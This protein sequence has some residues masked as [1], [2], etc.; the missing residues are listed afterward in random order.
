M[1]VNLAAQQMPEG[2]E[3][4]ASSGSA[5]VAYCAQD[6]IYYKEFLPRTPLESLKALLRGSRATRARKNSQALLLAGFDAPANLAW[7]KLSGGREYLMSGA[8]AGRGVSE[9]LQDFS[10]A[11]DEAS[12]A[13]R[14]QLLRELG[15]FIGRLHATGFIHGDLRSSNVFADFTGEQFRFALIDNERTIARVPPPGKLILKNLMQLNMHSPE[16][17][18]L[19]DRLQFY[20]AWKRQMRELSCVEGKLLARESYRWAMRRQAAKI[21]ANGG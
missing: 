15:V 18:T 9:Y 4:V 10:A 13:S 8:V 20:R 5:R 1:A 16:D 7:G 6:Q 14:R 21:R 3:L 17:L 12:S 19:R 11:N 2:W